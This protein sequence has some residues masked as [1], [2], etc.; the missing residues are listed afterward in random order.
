MFNAGSLVI[1]TPCTLLQILDLL[2]QTYTR[3][4]GAEYMHITD[5]AQKRW[6][7]R[8][9]ESCASTPHFPGP[10]RKHILERITAGA[11]LEEY[12]HTKYVGQKR[13]SLEG[14]ESL[15]PLMDEFIQNAGSQGIKETV[16]GMAH[17]GRLNVLVNVLGKKPGE[18]FS[19]FEGKHAAANGSGDV[20]YHQG[21][22]SDLDTP[23]GP[24][25]VALAFIVHNAVP[26]GIFHV[27]LNQR[28]RNFHLA[29]IH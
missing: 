10:T 13:F 21:F 26:D 2:Q 6:I 14:G 5:T 29:L 23:G 27:R 11:G 9:L 17:R 18:L 25:H 19:E 7:Q 3:S 12:L 1:A 4:I 28:S 20:K 8:R 15:I 16:V 24:V 22:S